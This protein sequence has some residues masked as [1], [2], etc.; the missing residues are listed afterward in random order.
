MTSAIP[1]TGDALLI[2]D[3]Q[4][5][6]LPGGSLAVPEGDAV[7]APLNAAIDAF[8]RRSLPIIASRDWHP[9]NHGSFKPQ[10]GI[11]PPHCIAQSSGAAFAAGLRLPA[12]ALVVSKATQP[13]TDAYSAFQG[14]DLAARLRSMGVKRLVVGGLATDYCVLETV[15]DALA[16][17]FGV[18]VLTD[19]VRAVDVHA[20]DGQAAVEKMA[21]AGALLLTSQDV[22]HAPAAAIKQDRSGRAAAPG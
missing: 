19:A 15:T 10:G 9:A 6:F 21:A 17:G 2:V 4:N 22:E 12:D 18:V 11:W 3:V 14:T 7:I 5:D 13:Q 20:G 1:A 16:L 8:A